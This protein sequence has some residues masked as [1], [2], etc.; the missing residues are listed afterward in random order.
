MHAGQHCTACSAAGCN[1]P[2]V[3]L[4]CMQANRAELEEVQQQLADAQAGLADLQA[5]YEQVTGP[6]RLHGAA[7]ILQDAHVSCAEAAVV[8]H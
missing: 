1:V 4:S 6:C 8:G 7:G 3:T 5:S 2:F